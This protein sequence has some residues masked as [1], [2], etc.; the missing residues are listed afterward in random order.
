MMP[1]YEYVSTYEGLN[2]TI[3]IILKQKERSALHTLNFAISILHR[4][5]IY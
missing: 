4:K 2:L 3:S 1:P 5:Q